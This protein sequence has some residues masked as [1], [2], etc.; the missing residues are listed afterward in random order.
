MKQII[1]LR[2]SD[3]SEELVDDKSD[4]EDE[5]K[6]E[7]KECC[8]NGSGSLHSW[9]VPSSLVESSKSFLR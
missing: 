8:L 5:V 4:K 2:E 6:S 1:E 9:H 3:L 7:K